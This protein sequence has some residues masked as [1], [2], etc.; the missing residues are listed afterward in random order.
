MVSCVLSQ[1]QSLCFS[2]CCP[3]LQWI[4]REKKTQ[5]QCWAEFQFKLHW[6]SFCCDTII[7]PISINIQAAKFHPSA[8]KL[9]CKLIPIIRVWI[10][11]NKAGVNNRQV[12]FCRLT[13]VILQ[14][15]RI[16]QHNNNIYWLSRNNCIGWKS[17][18]WGNK[19][20][21]NWSTKK[22]SLNIAD[23]NDINTDWFC[24]RLKIEALS[25]LL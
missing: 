12:F 20:S 24:N 9:A 8:L 15:A 2:S 17:I 6:I 16:M 4:Q 22:L 21:E 3:G 18:I 13:V 1:P 7:L 19:D 10:W 5:L 11:G 25:A 14:L 23:V